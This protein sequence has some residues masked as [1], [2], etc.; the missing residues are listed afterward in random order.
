MDKIEAKRHIYFDD[1]EM[2][3][4]LIEAKEVLR[5]MIQENGYDPSIQELNL[6]TV[7]QEE[8]ERLQREKLL[9][10]LAPIIYYGTVFEPQNKIMKISI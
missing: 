2:D 6:S 4:E 9:K 7:S 1:K 3:P 10:E 8:L 5:K